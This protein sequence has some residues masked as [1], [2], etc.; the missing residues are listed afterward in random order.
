MF[1]VFLDC[2]YMW[3][4]CKC[5]ERKIGV[6]TS[7]CIEFVKWMAMAKRETKTEPANMEYIDTLCLYV[8]SFLSSLQRVHSSSF[9]RLTL[10]RINFYFTFLMFWFG[11]RIEYLRCASDIYSNTFDPNILHPHIIIVYT[12]ENYLL[13]CCFTACIYGWKRNSDSPKLT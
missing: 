2:V 5:C 6:Q 11:L 3:R 13:S 1:Y 12:K 9:L 10:L 4:S 7:G 8:F